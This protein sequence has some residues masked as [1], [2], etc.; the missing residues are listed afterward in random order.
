M[1]F[2]TKEPTA[3]CLIGTVVVDVALIKKEMRM[4]G[5]ADRKFDWV[6]GLAVISG[7]AAMIPSL[8]A[9]VITVIVLI[10]AFF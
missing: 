5:S 9:L 6:A 4:A 3:R 10:A 7:A 1:C 2:S 8:A